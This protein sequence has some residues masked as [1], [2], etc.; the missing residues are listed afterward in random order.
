MRRV[1]IPERDRREFVLVNSRKSILPSGSSW[2]G[3]CAYDDSAR[4]QRIFT[5]I[6]L[7]ALYGLLRNSVCAV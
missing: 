5:A 3:P 6:A 4:G 1:R 7:V 2:I